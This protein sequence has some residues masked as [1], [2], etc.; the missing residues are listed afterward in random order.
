MLISK[1]IDF[2]KKY[3]FLRMIFGHYFYFGKSK[4][5]ELFSCLLCFSFIAL[6]I[7]IYIQSSNENIYKQVSFYVMCRFF[8]ESV[9]SLIFKGNYMER[10][11]SFLTRTGDILDVKTVSVSGNL[12]IIILIT[13]SFR[14]Y[15]YA[16][17]NHLIADVQTILYITVLLST[18]LNYNTKIVVFDVLYQRMKLL[19]MKFE[20]KFVSVN[21]IGVERCRYKINDIRNCLAVY[22]ILLECIEDIDWE[23]EVWV[24]M[25]SYL[26]SYIIIYKLV[27]LRTV[28]FAS[29]FF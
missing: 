20:R 26:Y 7:I 15:T 28:D 14:F 11:F 8:A 24:I 25:N 2:W 6:N 4:F 17:Y 21:I 1:Y 12:Y 27:V 16:K 9:N 10:M 13:F 19:R 22:S 5:M 3:I 18:Y 23:I 29:K